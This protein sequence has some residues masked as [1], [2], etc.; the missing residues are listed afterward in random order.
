MR[1]TKVMLVAA[2]IAVSSSASAQDTAVLETFSRADFAEALAANNA[3]HESTEGERNLKITFSGGIRADGLL[4][5]CQ[6]EASESECY[7]T[8]ILATFSPAEDASAEDVQRAINEYNYN[9]NFGRA[10]LAPDGKISA[11]MYIISDGGITKA[12]YARQIG[13]WVASLEDF[14]GYLYGEDKASV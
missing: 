2:A 5:A 12:N 14:F 10:Y 6:D 4:L 3:T 8:S 11:R 9:E 1:F 13:L 7:G